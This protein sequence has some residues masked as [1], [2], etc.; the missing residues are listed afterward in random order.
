AGERRAGRAGPGRRGARLV[1]RPTARARGA[2]PRSGDTGGRRLPRPG[3]QRPA[4]AA[5]MGRRGQPLGRLSPTEP[6]AGR[7]RQPRR[8][9]GRLLVV[10]I[11]PGDPAL[12]TAQARAALEAADVLVGYGAYLDQVRTWLPERDYRPSPIGAERERAREALAL[13]AEGRTVVL[14]SSG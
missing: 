10:G 3:H 1:G 13:A 7:R 6:R 4:A 11:G 9:G 5:G 14:V 8:A 2:L 12:L